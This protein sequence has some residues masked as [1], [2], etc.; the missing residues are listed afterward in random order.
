MK[1][2]AFTDNLEETVFEIPRV[3]EV[4]GCDDDSHF[5]TEIFEIPTIYSWKYISLL[6]YLEI[7]K[8]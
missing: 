4:H 6:S 3:D 8:L 5:N 7:C 1:H 2:H